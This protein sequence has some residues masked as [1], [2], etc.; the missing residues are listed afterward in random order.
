MGDT[1]TFKGS[2]PSERPMFSAG[3]SPRER[4]NKLSHD[5]KGDTCNNRMIYYKLLSFKEFNL[6]FQLNTIMNMLCEKA[7]IYHHL[8]MQ[9]LIQ[10]G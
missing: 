1:V 3:I 5:D 10:V 7:Y 9:V 2:F 4:S 6:I 8:Y